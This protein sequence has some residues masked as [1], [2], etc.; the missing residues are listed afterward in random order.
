[1]AA[2]YNG[3]GEDADGEYRWIN[4]AFVTSFDVTTGA[5]IERSQ[6][7]L[8]GYVTAIH[9]EQDVLLVAQAPTEWNEQNSKVSIV[10]FSE[11]DGSMTLGDTVSVAR[12]V[13]SQFHM[14]F[15][16]DQL[17]VFSG[18][19]WNDGSS[20]YLQTWDASDRHR[21]TPI[22]QDDFGVGQSL[23]GAVF[24][25][26]R[27]FAVT[28]ER[29]D[30]F[31]AFSIDP[32]GHVEEKSEF[33]VSGWNDFFRPVLGATRLI[34]IGMND[35]N[36]R[37]LAVSLYD[38]TDL[39]NPNPLI[40]RREV[41]GAD[42]DWN[43]SEASWDH[44]AFTVLDDAVN[45]TAP[46]GEAETGLVLLPFSGWSQQS[47]RR[48]WVSAVQI[49]SFSSTTVTRRGVMPHGSPVRRAFPAGPTVAANLSDMELSLYDQ[50][51]LDRPAPLG[52]LYLAPDYVKVFA[53][54]NHRVRIRGPEEDAWVPKQDRTAMAE[55]IAATDIADIATPVA[56]FE[57]A[58]D[59]SYF[60]VGDLLAVVATRAVGWPVFETTVRVFDLSDPTRPRPAGQLVTTELA[61]Q[62]D[63]YEMPS[64]HVTN[65]SLTAV[66]H[67][68]TW[69]NHGP[70]T[71]CETYVS[72]HPACP[73]SGD[74]T[75]I[76]GRRSCR[77][78]DG[79]PEYCVG[80]FAECVKRPGAEVVCTPVVDEAAIE[81]QLSTFC[82]DQQGS[83]AEEELAI[84]VIDLS[85]PASSRSSS[86]STC[87]P[88]TG[89][90]CSRRRPS[91]T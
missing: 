70:M 17:R 82:R 14:D 20:S 2:S 66:R 25:D 51:D 71:Q 58:P 83:R 5:L 39:T 85:D 19:E 38:I 88:R 65:R 24:L 40:T 55:V 56:R 64:Y 81:G 26:D 62:G 13:R 89:S 8:G 22:D 3:W 43:W 30:P 68:E 12:H 28:Y 7:D 86:R 53:Y 80:G 74:C 21:L 75:Q 73:T 60:Q 18:P 48:A 49:F 46:G 34:G 6:L 52:R 32:D 41:T 90:T 4:R 77:T 50:T 35:E 69:D 42:G 16:N 76:V 54:G 23:F 79:G 1:V 31:H 45:V 84:H 78:L 57:V 27:A 9:A 67:R 72:R 44:R 37:K 36:G 33:I 91:I 61:S 63:G 87:A 29:T 10:E 15:R 47:G 11:L 59:A